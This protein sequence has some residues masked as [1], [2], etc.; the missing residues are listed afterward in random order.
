MTDVAAALSVWEDA[1]LASPY[2]G[3]G[4]WLHGDIHATNVLV[5]EGRLA[6][7]IDWGSMGVG[8]PACDLL[9]AW[10]LFDA[11]A[12]RLFLDEMNVDDAT[13]R[14]GRGWAVSMALNILPYYRHTN[15]TLVAMA[16]RAIDE[17]LLDL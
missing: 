3:E 10:L 7:I 16:Q 8:D 1:L 4:A 15:P 6:A 12:R 11:P 14:R 5:R 13:L 17:V 2:A 9:P